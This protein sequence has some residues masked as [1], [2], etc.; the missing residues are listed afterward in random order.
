MRRNALVVLCSLFCSSLL[1]A[2]HQ[3]VVVQN[4]SVPQLK[5]APDAAIS[6]R[7]TFVAL[8]PCRVVDTRRAA[9]PYGGPAFSPGMRRDLE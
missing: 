6:G 2:T 3:R 1:A 8:D 4:W 5:A 7:A 9:G